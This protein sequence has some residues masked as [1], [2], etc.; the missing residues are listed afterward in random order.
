MSQ[1]LIGPL[2]SPRLRPPSALHCVALIHARALDQSVR[3]QTLK[4]TTKASNYQKFKPSIYVYIYRVAQNE[5]F[6]S[7]VFVVCKT[8]NKYLMLGVTHVYIVSSTVWRKF[9][10][11]CYNLKD[12]R[13]S[14]V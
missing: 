9:C 14:T 8:Q 11:T 2:C 13:L 6:N 12:T 5:L 10:W 7:V 3:L 4:E 1:S